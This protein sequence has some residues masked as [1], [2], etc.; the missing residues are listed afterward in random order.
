MKHGYF[1]T[2]LGF[3]FAA[4]GAALGLGNLWRFPYVVYENGGGAFVVLYF[5]ILFLVGLP[6]I[7]AELSVGKTTRSSS[8]M[9]FQ[10]MAASHRLS[11]VGVL[12]PVLCLFVLSS[13]AVVSGWVL[14]FFLSFLTANI[15]ASPIEATKTLGLLQDSAGLQIALSF[16]H[17]C[18]V[19]VIVARGV[20]LGIERS[21]GM[22]MPILVALVFVL[23]AKSLSLDHVMDS[24]KF[25]LYPDFSRLRLSS[26]GRA[27]GQALFTLG[28]GFGSMVTFGSYLNQRVYVPF[29][30]F[31]V[32]TLD[33]LL[34]LFAGILI[35]PLIQWTRLT[36][37][38]PDLLFRTVP[39]WLGS[40]VGG[41]TYGAGFFL[42]LYL[43]ALGASIALL[44]A[45]V[46]NVQEIWGKTR[47]SASL[48]VGA[49]CFILTLVPA[50]SSTEFE[51]VRFRGRGLF[52]ILDFMLMD[53][54]LPL[55]AF[56]FCVVL[57]RRLEGPEIKQDLLVTAVP[58]SRRLYGNWVVMIR[59]VIPSFIAL[60]V[61]LQAYEFLMALV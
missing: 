52:E 24:L 21:V 35:F 61:L 38:G 39:V 9:A 2:R 10:K 7:V 25:F 55:V 11:M 5:A 41:K 17:I 13:Y 1:G 50:L 51:W 18:G 3:Y 19:T 31:R 8:V 47:V 23:C 45:L 59:W 22:L 57:G 28:I 42:C 29:A 4:L 56:L 30:A 15:L 46:A 44:E 6:M 37:H 54:F 33:G 43:A 14:Y 49:V 58:Q 40:I 27:L 16:L 12:S 32:V 53:L 36:P 34:S 48:L 60:A 20:Q 26:V